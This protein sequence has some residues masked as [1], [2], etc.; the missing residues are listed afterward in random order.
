MNYFLFRRI[1]EEET[2]GG[3]TSIKKYEL[4]SQVLDSETS[5]T[6]ERERQY[7]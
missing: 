1:I 2:C 7:E 6:L 3:E 5:G 4:K